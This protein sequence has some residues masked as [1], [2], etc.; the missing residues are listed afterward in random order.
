MVLDFVG[1]VV[2]CPVPCRV[3]GAKAM[4]DREKERLSLSLDLQGKGMEWPS[5]L[6]VFGSL[7]GGCL[8]LGKG[9]RIS[10]PGKAN[11]L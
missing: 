6:S 10:V 8:G 9:R 4:G 11:E 1:V 5:L 3:E 2:V 7:G